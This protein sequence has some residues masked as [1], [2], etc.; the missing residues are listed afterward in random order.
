MLHKS[1]IRIV[2]GFG[3]GLVADMRRILRRVGAHICR[4]IQ[5]RMTVQ[6][7]QSVFVQ[8]RRAGQN[9]GDLPRRL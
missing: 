2:L 9:G 1:E 4:R 3:P 5:G 7:V 6:G 8:H